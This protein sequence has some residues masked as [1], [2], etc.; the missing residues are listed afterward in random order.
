MASTS[1][2][3]KGRDLFSSFEADIQLLN[4]A[5]DTRDLPPAHDAFDSA[6]A[7]LTAIR[8]SDIDREDFAQLGY[9]CADVCR[10][11]ERGLDGTPTDELSPSVFRAIE[12][13][14][15]TVTKIQ[16]KVVKR[17]KQSAASRM[18]NTK[19]DK[20]AI[21]AW[22][23][24]L[25][26]I[27]QIFNT[28]LLI[29]NHIML[30]DILRNARDDREGTNRLHQSAQ[31]IVPVG[32]LPPPPPWACFGRDTL[33]EN[34]AG[35]ADN[36][37]S[38]ALIGAGGIGKTS[39][40]LAILH[41]DRIKDR[42][43]DNRRFIRCDQFPP[44]RIHLLARLSKVIGAG[45]ENPEDLARLR[46]FLAS[47]EMILLLDN[48]E[49]ILDPQGPEAREMYAVVE[50]LSRFSNICLGITSRIST[51]PPRCKRPAI[52]TLST[53]SACEIF[54]GIHDT[55]ERSEIISDLVGRLEF[56]ALSITLLA[57]AASHNMWSYKRLAKEW[58]TQ[59]ARVLRTDYNESLAAAIELSLASPTFR[60]LGADARELLGVVAFYPQGIDE[61]NLDWLFP[62]IPEINTIFDKFC[63]LS[64]TSR[65]NEV[66]TML[67]PIRDHLGPQDPRSSPLLCSTK[68]HYFRRLSTQIYPKDPG[69]R[70]GEWIKSEDVN[71]EHL[72]NVFI[73]TGSDDVWNACARFLEHLYWFKKRPV[74]LAA[75][76]E[77][78][79]DDH[80][81]KPKCLYHLSRSFQSIGDFVEEKR[82]LSHALELWRK[83]GDNEYVAETL[84]C[85]SYTNR[86][87]NLLEEGIQQ[88]KEASEIYKWLGDTGQQAECLIYLAR[89]L[90]RGGQ[91]DAAEEAVTSAI[92][93]LPEKGEEYRVCQAHRTLGDIFNL[94]GEKGNA[95][96]QYEIA[97]KI[98]STF[99]W[100][101]E[102]FLIHYSLAHLFYGQ[103]EF[104]KALV[105]IEQAKSHAAEDKYRLGSV[106][107]MQARIWYLQ[108]RFEDATSEVLRAIE[109]FEKLGAATKL[110]M[111]RGI[112]GDIEQAIQILSGG[113]I[114]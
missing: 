73:P 20:D 85:L 24:E 4:R 5:K 30:V 75:A 38:F 92:E 8:D 21:A 111:C 91:L 32:E 6:S 50:E 57:T 17:G 97:L 42:F 9:S 83:G 16:K 95:I 3:Q 41:H 76:I 100:P 40:A 70:K 101:T 33:I 62:T 106:M 89:L 37:E 43:G 93:S 103:G 26:G 44:S 48:A 87:L 47:R 56:H 84:K 36:L 79:P 61:N 55:G 59:R 23:Q 107:A 29:N 69:F 88:L 10:A 28:E 65:R 13:L 22:R 105:H 18:L 108:R 49:S 94:K 14:T 52:P 25:N 71:V 113:E 72:L 86:R 102:L 66:I 39:I 80:D 109:I 74:S 53:E 112:L 63:L 12:H 82:L 15:T 19:K 60:K 110:V 2:R 78:L 68:D 54:Y 64:L 67:A 96:R 98:A 90:L 35:L 31:A 11:L 46:S 99:N 1:W 104:D 58:E 114:L 45:V 34:I 81:L 77:K 27:L 51:V 7:L